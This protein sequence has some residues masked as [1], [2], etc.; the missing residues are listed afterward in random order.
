MSIPVIASSMCLSFLKENVDAARDR[1]VLS[2]QDRNLLQYHAQRTAWDYCAG[3]G[4]TCESCLDLPV[5]AADVMRRLMYAYSYSDYQ[6]ARNAVAQLPAGICKHLLAADFSAT[7]K[8][9]PRRMAIGK[10]M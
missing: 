8:K 9:C 5:S 4:D 10:F 2:E 6:M 1:L 7:E 3:C